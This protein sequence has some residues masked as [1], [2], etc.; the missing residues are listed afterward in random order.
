MAGI[1]NNTHALIK[2]ERTLSYTHF[3]ANLIDILIDPVQKRESVMH[4]HKIKI[5]MMTS[6]YARHHK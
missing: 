3:P 1:D 5:N 4:G 6:F 2:C